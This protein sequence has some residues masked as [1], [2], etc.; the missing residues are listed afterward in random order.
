MGL[1]VAGSWRKR[2]D[3]HFFL[4]DFSTYIYRLIKPLN[5]YKDV[6]MALFR[7]ASTQEIDKLK[8]L[9][10]EFGPNEWNYLTP[11]GV[12]NEFALIERGNAQ[13]IIAVV[14]SEIIGFAV[15]IDGL[16]G[17]RYLEKYSPLEQMKF[18]GDVVVSSHHAGKG[19]ATRLLNECIQEA[20]VH[21][22]KKVLIERHE[23]NLASAGMMRKAGFE[24]VDTFYD[25][26]KRAAGSQ[27]S[28]ILSFDL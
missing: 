1:L 13:A 15:L 20:K 19:I 11:E 17:P 27:K 3:L 7:K 22:A 4:I 28:V 12:N 10:W 14:D 5:Y 24:I 21:H 26:E 25:P 9:L 2:L 16:V 23:E 8:S 18:V 6:V